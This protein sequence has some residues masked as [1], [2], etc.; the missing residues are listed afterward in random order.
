MDADLDPRCVHAMIDALSRFNQQVSSATMELRSAGNEG[1]EN[2]GD[3]PAGEKAN[4][5]LTQKVGV[6]D[7][8]VEE[9]GRIISKLIEE[10]E[11][12]EDISGDADDF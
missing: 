2:L 7:E 11:D 1:K 5:S 8:Q 3:D 6:I 10:L 12:A 9:T 4:E